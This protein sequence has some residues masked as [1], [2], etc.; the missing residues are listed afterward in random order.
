M[1]NVVGIAVCFQS[2]LLATQNN[3]MRS[4]T[5]GFRGR[6]QFGHC[7]PRHARPPYS[8]CPNGSGSRAIFERDALRLVL[9]QNLSLHRVGL[10]LTAVGAFGLFEP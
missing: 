4:L 1:S 7:A 9:C 5:R 10:C 6:R 8:L 3:T 2:V